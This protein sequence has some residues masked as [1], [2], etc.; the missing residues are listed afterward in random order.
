MDVSTLLIGAGIGLVVGY[1]LFYL[2]HKSNA[3]TKQEHEAIAAKLNDS[4]NALKLSDE[5]LKSA[6]EQAAAFQR[7]IESREIRIVC[8]TLPHGYA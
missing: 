5:R 6:Q 8:P 3:V 4:S 1:A 2:F 7:K